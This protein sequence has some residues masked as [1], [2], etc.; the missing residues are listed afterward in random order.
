MKEKK[1]QEN[2]IETAIDI[3]GLF[4]KTES[5]ILSLTKQHRENIYEIIVSKYIDDQHD[6]NYA[7]TYSEEDNSI[8]GWTVNIE[9]NG[10]QQPDVYFKF[11]KEYD[12]DLFVLYNKTLIL[13]CYNDDHYC[14]Y[15]F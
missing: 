13:R 15:L 7:V 3:N 5:D 4:S 11:D 14:K 2:A 12:I 9:V 10:Q 6:D 8:L 1:S